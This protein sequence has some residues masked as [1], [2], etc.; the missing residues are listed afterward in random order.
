MK[1]KFYVVLFVFISL[2]GIAQDN[3][4]SQFYANKL[5]LNPAFA[6]TDVCPRIILGYRDQWPGLSGE[7][8]SYTA[9]YDQSFNSMGLGLLFNADDAGRGVLKTNNIGFV[10]SPKV[11]LDQN[12][13]LSVAVEAGITQKTLDHSPLIFPDQLDP[14]YGVVSN[15]QEISEDKSVLRPDIQTGLMLYSKQMYVGYSIHHLLMPNISLINGV[16]SLYQRHTGHIGLNIYL[17]STV[18]EK[19]LGTG[20]KLSPQLI[21]HSQGPASELNFGLY[22]MKNKLTTGFWY[23]NQDAIA[24]LI[25]VQTTKFNFGFSYDITLSRLAANSMGALEL[26]TSYRFNCR[27]KKKSPQKMICPSF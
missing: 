15:I 24:L 21:Y 1:R 12:W 26:S 23:R 13:T 9:S 2:S 25:G 8:V 11:Q 19:R 7:Y 17:P 27:T 22:Y 14:R 18:K 5:Y 4:Y 20:P 10:L 16:D 6:G 3:H